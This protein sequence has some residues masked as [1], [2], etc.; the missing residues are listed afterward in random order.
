VEVRRDIVTRTFEFAVR[1]IR[2]GERVPRHSVAGGLL[3]SQVVRVGTSI[4]ANVEEAQTGES[5]ADFVPKNGIALKEARETHCW[6][7]LLRAAG[8]LGEPDVGGL[9]Q[10]A[11]ELRRILG[12]IV[13]NS[14][15]NR[16][17]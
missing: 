6:L 2:L 3:S 1:V 13:V 7:R 8:I 16:K 15:R 10:E 12:R 5:R 14:K 17:E 11:D 9:I 4:G